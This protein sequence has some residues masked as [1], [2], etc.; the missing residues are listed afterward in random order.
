M[1]WNDDGVGRQKQ[2]ENVVGVKFA[3]FITLERQGASICCLVSH[4][5]TCREADVERSLKISDSTHRC[6]RKC[7]FTKCID[8]KSKVT[9]GRKER[10][11][12]LLAC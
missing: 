4:S 6:Q 1:C 7:V 10:S 8:L 12:C 9:E 2:S 11:I 5:H 3:I